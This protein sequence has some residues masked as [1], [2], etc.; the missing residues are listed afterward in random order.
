MKFTRSLTAIL[1]TVAMMLSVF[2][3]PAG[4]LTASDMSDYSE[5]HWAAAALAWA[6]ENDLIKGYHDGTIRADANLTRAEMATIVNRAFGASVLASI[7]KFED[8]KDTDWFYEEMS[9]AV[10][11]GTFE[12][13]DDTHLRPDDYIVREE[14]FVVIARALVLSGADVTVLEKFGD[15]KNISDWAVAL[16][17]DLAQRQYINGSPVADSEKNNLYPREYITRAEFAQLLYNIFNRILGDAVIK[18]VKVEGNLL[19]NTVSDLTVKNVEVTGD[20]IIAD[21]V[22]LNKV[23]LENV[24]INGRLVIRGGK[25][26]K[27]TKVTADG[28]VVVSNNNTTVN[29][30]NYKDE[31]VF[32]DIIA[33]TPVTFKK[34]TGGGSISVGTTDTYRVTFKNGTTGATL[35]T[36]TAKKGETL[37]EKLFHWCYEDAYVSEKFL[38]GTAN[39]FVLE[40]SVR[41]DT[42]VDANGVEFT[43]DTPVTGNITVYPKWYEIN[44]G[45]K[46]PEY[47][48][49]LKNYDVKYN[50][51]TRAIDTVK[52]FLFLKETA[53]KEVL[54]NQ[55]LNDKLIDVAG[56][57]LD[58][59]RNIKLIEHEV[60]IVETLGKEAIKEE[61]QQALTQPGG[62]A[63][64]VDE[65]III[66]VVEELF[67]E[68]HVT[69]TEENVKVIE[70]YGDKVNELTYEDIEE[71][72]PESYKQVMT[73]EE[74]KEAFEDAKEQYSTEINLTLW[75]FHDQHPEF[76]VPDWLD[77]WYQDYLANNP[78][79]AHTSAVSMNEHKVKSTVV[80]KINV[81]S[82]IV[83]PKYEQAMNKF[84]SKFY[85]KYKDNAYFM[86]L[87]EIVNPDYLLDGDKGYQN[88][89]ELLTGYTLKS[90]NYYF[91][92]IREAVVMAD[93]AGKWF[94]DEANMG[95][96]ELKSM[97]DEL[98]ELMSEYMTKV[99]DLLD[100]YIDRVVN[101]IYD[102]TEKEKIEIIEEYKDRRLEQQDIDKIVDYLKTAIEGYNVT[103]KS[104]Y[105]RAYNFDHDELNS[106]KFGSENLPEALQGSNITD[107]FF[108]EIKGISGWLGRSVEIYK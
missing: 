54:N 66:D 20:L 3:I 93:E 22:C 58:E 42:W 49:K 38:E 81:I 48:S 21:G 43:P 37:G 24:K 2:C 106:V 98:G 91:D 82:G 79:M 33:K 36:R 44:V 29:F 77:D 14:A 62:T 18:D 57:V 104:A 100:E 78:P 61:I 86:R 17:S 41:N 6:V 59:N 60:C 28:G 39:E 87:L 31:D 52:D 76:E 95:D 51:E 64:S 10:N 32:K 26:V 11:M 107:G 70:K 71:D 13:S 55:K 35:A 65:Q 84:E 80:I 94:K 88:D 96:D 69:I 47:F 101:K 74:M 8:V 16:L 34:R 9:K 5:E 102:L 7:T 63:P 4:A 85:D 108:K 23:T 45:V 103:T 73:E 92:V 72:I 53:I 56:F 90:N 25:N 99:N 46:A 89:D 68:K 75:Q 1:L 15:A 30:D 67:E 97:A 19:L 105:E 50:S 12:G 40:R 27:L 83:E